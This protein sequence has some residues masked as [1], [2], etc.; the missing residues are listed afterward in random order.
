M[1]F[2]ETHKDARLAQAGAGN[3]RLGLRIYAPLAVGM[4]LVAVALVLISFLPG[5]YVTYL[6]NL[7]I[8]NALCAIGLCILAGAA[9]QLSLGTAAIQ[10]IAAYT[11]GVLSNQYGVPVLLTLPLGAIAA[12]LVGTTLAIPALRLSGLH[13]PVLTMAFGVVAVQLISKGGTFTGG[14]SGLNIPTAEFLGFHFDS[15]FRVLCLNAP[16]FVWVAWMAWV[17]LKLKPGRALR[18]IRFSPTAAQALGVNTAHYN[19]VGFAFSSFIIGIGGVL[20]A[21]TTRYISTD[22][23]TLW[24]SVYFFV[25]IAVGGMTSIAGSVVGAIFVTLLPEFLRGVASVAPFILGV[26]LILINWLLP[27]GLVSAFKMTRDRLFAR[28][29]A[30]LEDGQ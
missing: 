10:A 11:V 30:R 24:N 1:T 15:D 21:L 27:G 14:T 7:C 19:I 2:L 3:T 9:G 22:D 26:I 28:R 12:T 23:F 4:V 6:I 17:F 20:Y 25:M 18:V 29:D 13:L 5:S 8:I 16:I